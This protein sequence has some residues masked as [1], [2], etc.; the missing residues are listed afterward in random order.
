MVIDK[1]DRLS[2]NATFLLSLR[3][4]G[5]KFVCCDMPQADRF[6]VGILALVAERER[7]LISERTKAGLAVAKKRG[8]KL[9]NPK[10]RESQQKATDAST[11]SLE[12]LWAIQL[13]AIEQIKD[14]GVQ[15]YAE[16]A[17]CLSA[18]GVPT[19][20]GGSWTATLV[21]NL[22]KKVLASEHLTRT[23]R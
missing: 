4:S 11:N 5:V 13:E 19:A 22:T 20:R 8:V 16:I 15:S 7:E 10:R 17:R 6:T 21:R 12:S 9:G 3:D 14:A 18:R 1:L 23:N 2:R